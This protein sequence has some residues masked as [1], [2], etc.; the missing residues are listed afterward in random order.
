MP[1]AMSRRA[2]FLGWAER[3]ATGSVLMP[4]GRAARHNRFVASTGSRVIV[5]SLKQLRF[6]RL[7]AVGAIQVSGVLST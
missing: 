1:T 3:K 4:V 7:A 2:P 6:A 5:A